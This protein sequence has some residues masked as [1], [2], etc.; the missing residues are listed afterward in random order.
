MKRD[1]RLYVGIGALIL[2]PAVVVLA[3]YLVGYFKK[4]TPSPSPSPGH[5]PSPGPEPP[6][7]NPPSGYACSGFG[8]LQGEYDAAYQAFRLMFNPLPRGCANT[9]VDILIRIDG[10]QQGFPE[11]LTLQPN[12]QSIVLPATV[13][14]KGTHRAEIL[15]DSVDTPINVTYPIF[16]TIE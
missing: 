4:P 9:Q 7:P 16:Y 3:L 8:N 5:R 1:Y 14:T 6:S 12:M 15:I 11:Q 13:V 10:V 2:I